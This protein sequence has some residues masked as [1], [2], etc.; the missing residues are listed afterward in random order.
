MLILFGLSLIAVVSAGPGLLPDPAGPF[1]VGYSQHVIPHVTPSDPTPGS[2]SGLL[3]HLYYPTQDNNSLPA[4]PY[5]DAASAEHWSAF[6]QLPKEA[7]L[8]LKTALISNATALRLSSGRPTIFFSPGVG[9]NAWM[10]YSLLAHLAANGYTVVAIDHPGEPPVLQRPNSTQ[11]TG[12]GFQMPLTDDKIHKILSY[13]VAD[14]LAVMA[15]FTAHVQKTSAPFNTSEFL[16][17]GHS[18]GGA[19]SVASI[20]SHP[21]ARAAVNLDGAFGVANYTVKSDIRK[22]VL[23][24]S[25][26]NHTLQFDPTWAEFQDAQ[27]GFWE[28]VSIYGSAHLD[29]S[30]VALWNNS[31]GFRSTPNVAIGPIGGARAM[32]IA[33][34]YLT[35]FFEWAGGSSR[36]KGVLAAPSLQWSEVIYV[37]GSNV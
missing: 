12:W 6:I 22:P 36:G 37:N 25:S 13:R 9:I 21:K 20:P 34:K 2:G 10:Y 29:Y 15:W 8:N 14:M 16:A 5:F 17:L 30:D 4:P 19:A 27:T 35:D 24:M 1:R 26:I 28:S 32:Q 31:L 11:I 23:L 33:R 3:A 7:L 18:L